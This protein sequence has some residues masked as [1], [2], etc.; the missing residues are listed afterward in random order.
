MCRS[1]WR[2]YRTDRRTNQGYHTPGNK[3]TDVRK[4]SWPH[5]LPTG[6]LEISDLAD[7]SCY[8]MLLLMTA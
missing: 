5:T 3:M 7:D 4:L 8:K 6:E 2:A 1:E